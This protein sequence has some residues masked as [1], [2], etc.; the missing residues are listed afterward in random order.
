MNLIR[1]NL[2][3]SDEFRSKHSRPSK[4]LWEWLNRFYHTTIMASRY[5]ET[6][7][8]DERRQ[9]SLPKQIR[10]SPGKN[11]TGSGNQVRGPRTNEG[12]IPE[13]ERRYLEQQKKIK[14]LKDNISQYIRSMYNTGYVDILPVEDN[15]D[16]TIAPGWELKLIE[17]SEKEDIYYCQALQGAV[18]PHHNHI[19][20]EYLQVLQGELL[21]ELPDK[22]Y[23]LKEGQGLK[24]DA[25]VDH[26][27]IAKKFVALLKS[28]RPPISF[29]PDK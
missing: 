23:I 14:A 4:D 16:F 7:Q 25:M 8:G 15:M 2:T 13:K 22:E 11:D 12:D 17:S 10:R 28:F 18:L 20:V 21:V 9:G 6:S 5:S 24:I 27:L 29:N 1:M 19:Q 26:K 3:F